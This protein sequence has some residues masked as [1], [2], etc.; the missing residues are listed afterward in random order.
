MSRSK[1]VH[2][3]SIVVLK[4]KADVNTTIRWY[5]NSTQPLDNDV[6][7]GVYVIDGVDRRGGVAVATSHLELAR[8][9]KQDGGRYSC[10]SL[11]D[12]SD[13]DTIVL[14]VRDNQPGS[15]L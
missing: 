4:C 3:G 1:R 9:R 12:A 13:N 8:M 10:R 7:K 5:L 14:T 11:Q 6:S 15:F 2:A